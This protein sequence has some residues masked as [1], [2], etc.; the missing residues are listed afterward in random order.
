MISKLAP[1][2]ACPA[3]GLLL[4]A[5]GPLWPSTDVTVYVS[6]RAPGLVA[7]ARLVED[8]PAWARATAD[9]A[10]E[11]G[12]P[13]VRFV[14]L[15]PGSRAPSGATVVR[16]VVGGAIPGPPGYHTTDGRILVFAN[17]ASRYGYPLSAVVSH[18]VEEFLVDPQVCLE[19]A[20]EALEVADPVASRSYLVPGRDGDP[21]PV[22]DFVYPSWFVPGAHGPYDRAG[23]LD[24]PREVAAG[25]YAERLVGDRWVIDGRPH[26]GTRSRSLGSPCG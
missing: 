1:F 26:G 14:V 12:T 6:D 19:Q 21:V 15:R 16:V 10:D 8:V 25:G 24:R 4:V 22:S 9:L 18:E 5:S 20:G 3:L 13:A 2:L 17:V 23:I 11:W 7:R